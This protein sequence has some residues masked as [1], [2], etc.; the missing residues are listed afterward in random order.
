MKPSLL[1]RFS[2][3]LTTIVN[4]F[5]LDLKRKW[6]E[7]FAKI[8]EQSSRKSYFINLTDFIKKQTRKAT[9]KSSKGSKAQRSQRL[10][11]VKEL[12]SP[13][14][15]PQ[16]ALAK[17]VV[18]I[19]K[20]NV[21]ASIKVTKYRVSIKSLYNLKKLLQSIMMRYRNESCFMLISIL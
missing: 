13:P 21:F 14:F 5:Y 10:N 18:V 4:K 11:K 16:L 9:L 1:I 6:V 20:R 3:V 2:S 19:V 8:M 12:R 7:H 17:T 15:K